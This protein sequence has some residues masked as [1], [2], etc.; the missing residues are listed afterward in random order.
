MSLLQHERCIQR[1]TCSRTVQI[2]ELFKS[3][4]FWDVMLCGSCKNRRFEWTYRFH[5]QGEMFLRKVFQLLTIP[6]V[7]PGSLILFSLMME[8]THSSEASHITRATRRHISEYGV[9]H[10]HRCVCLCVCV[11]LNLTSSSSLRINFHSHFAPSFLGQ[12]F[13]FGNLF[14][15]CLKEKQNKTHSLTA[16][17]R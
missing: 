9:L 15:I 2:I 14:L 8:A 3:V 1:H 5:Y 12:Y 7:V 11:N 4:D 13:S 10:S 6:N 16:G 17:Q